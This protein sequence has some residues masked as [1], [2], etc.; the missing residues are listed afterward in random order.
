LAKPDPQATDV[1][2]VTL[3]MP[4]LNDADELMGATAA[5]IVTAPDVPLLASPL[6]LIAAT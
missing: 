1:I 5:L 4:T 3:P 2:P 6:L